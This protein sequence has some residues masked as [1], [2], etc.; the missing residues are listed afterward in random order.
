MKFPNLTRC[1]K[2][3]SFLKPFSTTAAAMSDNQ[4]STPNSILEMKPYDFVKL[5]KKNNEKR[6]FV[7]FDKS[8]DSIKTSSQ[9][10]NDLKVFC[11]TDQIDYKNHEGFF[12]EIGRR[13]G[14]LMG[15]FVWQTNRGQAVW[16]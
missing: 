1:V 5:M 11:E 2:V 6:C 15:A 12:L 3:Q 9:I 13:T 7:V 4:A 10:F 16:L 14:A 8:S